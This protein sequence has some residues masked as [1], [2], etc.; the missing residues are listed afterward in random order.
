MK[1]HI[2]KI[3]GYSF[4]GYVYVD[5]L[6][7]AQLDALRIDLKTYQSDT[8]EALGEFVVE[9]DDDIPMPQIESV[10]LFGAPNGKTYTSFIQ[11]QYCDL[12][13]KTLCSK[14]VGV[15]LAA[16]HNIDLNIDTDIENIDQLHTD[17]ENSGNDSNWYE[18][19]LGSL[20]DDA[21]DSYRDSLME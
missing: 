21:Y 14:S 7:P 15:P 1:V 5:E 8:V 3:K 16:Q 18:D 11:V 13:S 2:N 19:R 6:N 20:A 9:W 10:S 12:G 17:L 4:E